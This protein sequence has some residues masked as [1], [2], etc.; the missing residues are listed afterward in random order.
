[1]YEW[2]ELIKLWEREQV[3]PEQVIGQLLKHGEA[4]HTLIVALQRHVEQVEQRLPHAPKR[5]PRSPRGRLRLGA[6]KQH[7]NGCRRERMFTPASVTSSVRGTDQDRL[8]YRPIDWSVPRTLPHLRNGK[9][10]QIAQGRM[11]KG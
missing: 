2:S 1:M 3:T 5:R 10:T 8:L 7:Y 6:G 4:Q 9:L 11:L